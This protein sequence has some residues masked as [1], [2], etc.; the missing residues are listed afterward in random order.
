[1]RRGGG[2]E[3]DA[4]VEERLHDGVATVHDRV[5]DGTVA[6]KV[7]DCRVGS[8]VEQHT[9]DRRVSVD[10]RV[11]QRLTTI[12]VGLSDSNVLLETRGDKSEP[13]STG[14]LRDGETSELLAPAAQ[15]QRKR[16]APRE[17][18]CGR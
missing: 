3:A 15:G 4:Q 16:D 9:T 8:S 14:S 12:D 2:F 1:M 11:V 6:V 17:D 10:R 7:E 5:D 18:S 13:A